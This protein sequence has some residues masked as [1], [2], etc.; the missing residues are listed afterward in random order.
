MLTA[1]LVITMAIGMSP[2]AHAALIYDSSVHLT[3]EGFGSEPRDL[4]LQATGGGTVDSGCVGVSAGGTITIGAAS[5]IS[6]ALVHDG[7]GATNVGGNEPSPHGDNN[8]YGIPTAGSLGISSA[9]QIGILFNPNEPGK[10]SANVVD[11]ALK[12]YT[13]GGAL[14]GAIDGQQNFPSTDPGTGIAGFVFL[15]S[16]DEYSYVNA[17]LAANPLLALEATITDIGG[18]PESFLIFKHTGS[19][20]PPVPVPAALPLMGSALAALVLLRRRRAA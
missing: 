16:P 1:G 8:K 9:D 10:D 7:N 18:G 15:V 3:G 6:D 5:C 11:L 2:L 13:S 17:L 19:T 14:L 4:T 12:F 20:P